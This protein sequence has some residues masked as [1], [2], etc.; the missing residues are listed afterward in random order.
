VRHY[1]KQE[2]Q[3]GNVWS[4][5][6]PM[7]THIGQAKFTADCALIGSIL[8][9]RKLKHAVVIVAK[10]SGLIEFIAMPLGKNS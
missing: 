6:W 9:A 7:G 4:S 8:T 1:E 3:R 2:E 5:E 10:D